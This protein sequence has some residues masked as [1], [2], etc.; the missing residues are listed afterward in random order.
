MYIKG[1]FTSSVE[2]AKNLVEI[3]DDKYG[4]N[5]DSTFNGDYDLFRK[6]CTQVTM[7]LAG[8][9]MLPGGMSVADYF[10]KFGN[11][12]SVVP[13]LNIGFLQTYFYNKAFTRE[14][15]ENA[16][17][18]LRAKYEGRNALLQALYTGAA[19]NLKI[20]DGC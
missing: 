20:I 17:A 2:A 18:E 5:T 14:E 13:D 16:I 9:G 1:D 19:I 11:S 15:Y 8:K 6:N 7:E 4:N 10:A 12:V 3:Y